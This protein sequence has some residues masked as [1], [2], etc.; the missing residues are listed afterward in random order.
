MLRNLF[1]LLPLMLVFL[2]YFLAPGAEEHY[3]LHR[4]P[5][6]HREMRTSRLDQTFYVRSPEQ[7][8][9]HFPPHTRHRRRVEQ[10]VEM[11]HVSALESNCLYERQQQ[12][13]LLRVGNKKERERANQMELHSCVKLQKIR[14][15]ESELRG[16]AQRT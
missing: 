16:R 10:N 13:R 8:E 12:H 11:S 5:Q 7:F 9:D 6:F 3:Q 14:T 15:K 2:M 1:Q 4:S